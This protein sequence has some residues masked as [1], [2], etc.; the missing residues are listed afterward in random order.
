MSSGV[1]DI[2]V[3]FLRLGVSQ[4]GFSSCIQVSSVTLNKMINF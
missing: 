3:D 1:A 4:R 2:N